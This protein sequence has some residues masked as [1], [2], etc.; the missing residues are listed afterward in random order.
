M[1]RTLRPPPPR[2]QDTPGPQRGV[3]RRWRDLLGSRGVLIVWSGA[4][5][6]RPPS[7]IADERFGAWRPVRPA[8]EDGPNGLL[9]RPRRPVSVEPLG[10]ANRGAFLALQSAVSTRRKPVATDPPERRA[11]SCF[12]P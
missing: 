4:A 5:R 11:S 12:G 8:F 1:R 2:P 10:D 7:P 6:W 9:E 3:T